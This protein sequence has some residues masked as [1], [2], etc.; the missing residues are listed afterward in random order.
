M[1]P[2][3]LHLRRTRGTGDVEHIRLDSITLAIRLGRHLLPLLEDCLGTAKV[4][5]NVTLFKAPNDAGDELTL[6]VAELVEGHFPLGIADA[7]DDDLLGRLRCNA[8]QL[9]NPQDE[10]QLVPDLTSGVLVPSFIER[11]LFVAVLDVVH[12]GLEFDEFYLAEVFVVLSL[13][14]PFLAVPLASRS[15]HRVFDD[16]DERVARDGLVAVDD[17]DQAGKIADH[18]GPPSTGGNPSL[19]SRRYSSVVRT[20]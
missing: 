19:P 2:R 5:D 9:F 14:R 6:P 11:N 18:E 20:S 15:H 12:Y 8:T 1:G 7:L 10:A 17:V 4:N 13:E 3:K 16:F